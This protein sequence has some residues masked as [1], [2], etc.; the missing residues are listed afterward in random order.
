M[1]TLIKNKKKRGF[2]LIELMIVI[3]IFTVITTV[4]LFDQGKLNSNVLLTNLAYDVALTVREAQSY[5][6][7]VRYSTNNNSASG[8]Y[9]VYLNM[10]NPEEIK[11]F[12]DLK[13]DGTYVEADDGSAEKTYEFLNQRGNRIAGIC[14]L[15]TSGALTEYGVQCPGVPF[16]KSV[17]NLNITFKRPDPE[18]NFNVG[19]NPISG[20]AYIVLKSQDGTNCRAVVVEG[21]GQVRVE[22]S[23]SLACS[24][25][26]P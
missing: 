14:V 9:G 13:D 26:T 19:G 4:A 7:G 5:G 6:V 24:S 3:A 15:D 12:H 25:V 20:P 22:G 10:I 18:A 21:S 23:D 11:V 16:S 8:G 2:S 1:S 17:D